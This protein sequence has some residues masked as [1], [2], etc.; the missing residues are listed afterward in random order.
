[1]SRARTTAS[2]AVLVPLFED[3]G[4]LR[5]IL[6]LR[7]PNLR[8]HAGQV[9][10]PGGRLDPGRTPVT[11]ALRE[12][13]EE[14]ALEPDAV[15][16]IGELDHLRTIVSNSF[17]VPV[18][19]VLSGRQPLTP[20]PAEV[21]RIFDV[22]MSELLSDGVYREERWGIPN[23]DRAVSFFEVEGET[24][25]GAT[26]TML[27]NF[28]GT[29][30]GAR[31][32][33]PIGFESIAAGAITLRPWEPADVSFVYDACQDP[34]IQRWTNLPSPF[35]ASDADRAVAPVVVP[36]RG[37]QGRPLRDRARPTKA[38]CSARSRCAR[39]TTDAGRP[40]R[41]LGR[42][43]SPLPG[44][45]HPRSR[46]AVAV[47][48]G[49]ARPRRGLRRRAS[50]QR[51]VDES[52]R[53]LRLPR[54]RRGQLHAARPCAPVDPL[55]VQGIGRGVIRLGS[56]PQ[57]ALKCPIPAGCVRFDSCQTAERA[58]R[59]TSI[60]RRFAIHTASPRGA[61]G[62]PSCARGWRGVP[63]LLVHGWPETKRICWRV[64]EPLAAAGLRGDRARPARLRRQRRRARRLPRRAR[65][66][67]D[68]HALVHD[69]LGHERVVLCRRRPRRPGHPGPGAALSATGS[70]AWCCSTRRCRTTRSGWPASRTRPAR[71]ASDYFVRQGTDADALAAELATPEQRRRYIATFY[72][73]R[74]W[75]HPGAFTTRG[76]RTLG[77]AS[78]RLPHR[79]VRRR[80]QAACQLR[81]LRERRSTR[82][83]RSEPRRCSTR[84]PTRRRSSCSAPA[85]T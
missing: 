64:I 32:T 84:N 22:S 36:P 34:E 82:P 43:R 57:M 3:E 67:R 53:A 29:R 39:S 65:H 18:V 70:T 83:A 76:R 14:T 25:W 10:F 28:L 68:L 27:K 33:A 75:A 35:T 62:R 17:I 30:V 48:D 12:A 47:G 80:R 21:D 13:H 24:V 49:D 72:T 4:E 66:S 31:V 54:G 1:M 42:R 40:H 77:G 59:P 78:R 58:H 8:S 73:S 11:A 60:R 52:A 69:H 20:N 15:E 56:C 26:G 63:L 44:C 19:G 46:G 61:S 7:N 81:R 6:T 71:E 16:V 55:R 45:C 74:F 5:V 79:A 38:S 37:G 50:R 23:I 51:H 41:L 9:S 2:S 85:T